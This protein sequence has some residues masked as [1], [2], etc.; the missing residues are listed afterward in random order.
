[1]KDSLQIGLK[2]NNQTLNIDQTL[3]NVH[4]QLMQL[5][6]KNR[7]DRIILFKNPIILQN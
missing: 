3:K 4:K 6:A 2:N 1:M 7:I 5:L